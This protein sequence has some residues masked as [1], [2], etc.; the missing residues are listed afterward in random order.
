[1][2]NWSAGVLLSAALLMAA[3]AESGEPEQPGTPET[4]APASSQPTEDA[5]PSEGTQT[6]RGKVAEGVEAGCLILR[7]DG[8]EYL[9]VGAR[10]VPPGTE[11]EVTGHL[12]QEVSSFCQQ[13]TP[14]MVSDLRTP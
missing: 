8:K 9:L 13:G 1:M 5:P 12:T 10:D 7:A 6:L 11:V 2:R 3:C 14:F 4:S